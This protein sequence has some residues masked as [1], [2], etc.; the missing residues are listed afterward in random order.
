M[1]VDLSNGLNASSYLDMVV[2]QTFS[3]CG[4]CGML[5]L[6][7]NRFHVRTYIFGRRLWDN[8]WKRPIMDDA[9]YYRTNLCTF[10]QTLLVRLPLV[11][12]FYA[13]LIFYALYVAI[14]WPLGYMESLDY[15]AMVITGACFVGF[16]VAFAYAAIRVETWR[17]AKNRRLAEEEPKPKEKEKKSP[18]LIKL[19]WYR[20]KDYHDQICTIVEIR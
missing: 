12:G 17:A 4:S 14:I 5:R 15:A 8:F 18:G 19:I 1:S 10:I 7:K 13:A 20:I 9:D 11:L 2:F 6:D 3:L 16:I